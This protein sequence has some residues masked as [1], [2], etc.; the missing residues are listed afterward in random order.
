MSRAVPGIVDA[1]DAI[2]VPTCKRLNAADRL[3]HTMAD[4]PGLLTD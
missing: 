2:S 4:L 3:V 1:L